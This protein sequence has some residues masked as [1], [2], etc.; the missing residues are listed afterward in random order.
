MTFSKEVKNEILKSFSALSP[1]CEIVALACIFRTI[2]SI[3][4]TQKG[5]GLAVTSESKEVVKFIGMTVEK[6]FGSNAEIVEES[7]SSSS[8]GPRF[9]IT[10]SEAEEI[11]LQCGIV[12][13]DENGFRQINEIFDNRLLEDKCCQKVFVKSIF[14][15]AGSVT[16]PDANR[17]GYHMEFG[18]SNQSIT[19]SLLTSFREF[20]MSPKKL[21]RKNESVIYFKGGEEIS[22]A[23]ALMG[24]TKSLF[25]LQNLIVERSVRNNA[26]R[27]T[28]C[29]SANIDKMVEAAEK[30]LVA[31]RIIEAAVGLNSLPEKLKEAAILRRENISESLDEL[32]AISCGSVTKSGL[33]HRFRKII[34]IADEIKNKEESL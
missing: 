30:Q 8:H 11:L 17:E 22:D 28:N 34:E 33:N 7:A 10:V 29:I 31:I 3:S 1:C 23:L 16:L 25:Q 19:D 6:L 4:L 2:G 9:Q 13:R 18:L 27:Q 12:S 21:V 24:A 15:G 20:E 14:V 5:L 26:N 32:S